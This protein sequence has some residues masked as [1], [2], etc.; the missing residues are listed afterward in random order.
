MAEREIITTT[1]T[2]VTTHIKEK[3]DPPQK[4]SSSDGD[5]IM[6]FLKSSVGCLLV[7]IV[8]IIAMQPRINVT[9]NGGNNNIYLSK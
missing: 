2:T 1:T 3:E 7:A 4:E 8:L 9:N 5:P 6:G